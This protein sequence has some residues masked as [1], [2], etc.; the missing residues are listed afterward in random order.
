MKIYCKVARHDHRRQRR[1]GQGHG[2]PFRGSGADVAIV[3]RQP[4][5]LEAAKAEVD[6]AGNGKVVALP[7]DLLDPAATVQTFKDAEQALGKSTYSS[8]TRVLRAPSRSKA[9]PTRNGM[10]LELKLMAAVRLCR[11][12]LPAVKQRKWGRIIN[13]Y[14]CEGTRRRR[15]D[16]VSRAADL[17]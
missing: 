13:V 8:T 5:I 4:E 7:C 11:N 15:P 3:A 12:A 2:D 14:R 16:V 6:A 1:T 9:L 17:R 10:N